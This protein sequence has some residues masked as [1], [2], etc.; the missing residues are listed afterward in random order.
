MCLN[1]FL[2]LLSVSCKAYVS[3]KA[4]DY[5]VINIFMIIDKRRNLDINDICYQC[6]SIVIKIIYYA[7]LEFGEVFGR[8][9]QRIFS[10]LLHASVIKK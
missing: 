7:L 3:D 10:L 2:D 9:N 5:W 4:R 6:R 1:V 8:V